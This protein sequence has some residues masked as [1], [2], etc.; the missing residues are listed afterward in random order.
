M[1]PKEAIDNQTKQLRDMA[2]TQ[3]EHIDQIV[4]IDAEDL[5]RSLIGLLEMREAAMADLADVVQDEASKDTV[6]GLALLPFVSLAFAG[7]G[8][9]DTDINYLLGFH[10]SFSKG[11]K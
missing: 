5:K 1:K 8:L 10:R 2:E 3:R 4:A 6:N 11:S 9:L 7:V